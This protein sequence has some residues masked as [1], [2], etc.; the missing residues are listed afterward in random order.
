MTSFQQW[1]G[2]GPIIEAKLAPCCSAAGLQWRPPLAE[3]HLGALHGEADAAV[4]GLLHQGLP[5]HQLPPARVRR[6][7]LGS[8]HRH[9]TT[10]QMPRT[11]PEVRAVNETKFHSAWR[12]HSPL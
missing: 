6:P 2:D 1:S 3:V 8:V 11:A 7:V 9:L 4:L 12:R 5:V 10:K